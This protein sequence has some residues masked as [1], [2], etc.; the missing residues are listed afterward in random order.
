M[1]T[2]ENRDDLAEMI[3]RIGSIRS[4]S[5]RQWG[6]M[7]PAE[8]TCHCTDALRLALGEE[9]LRL[10]GGAIRRTVLKWLVLYAPIHWPKNVP[11]AAPLDPQRDG[12]KPGELA[13]DIAELER[14]CDRFV[15]SKKQ[16]ARLVHPL[17]GPLSDAQWLRWGY[18]HTDH[19]LRQFG[20]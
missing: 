7:S 19:H 4:D 18:L 5:P 3:R 16:N 20:L 6:R 8:M 13:R 12:T 10:V 15:L 17:F 1:K 11:T 14:M 9:K 2:L